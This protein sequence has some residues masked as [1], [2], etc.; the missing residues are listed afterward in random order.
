MTRTFH[1]PER[2][3]SS[4]CRHD[5]H[6]WGGLFSARECCSYPIWDDEDEHHDVAEDVLMTAQAIMKAAPHVW[7]AADNPWLVLRFS[8]HVERAR[9]IY[10]NW[11]GPPDYRLWALRTV[12]SAGAVTLSDVLSHPDG[13][14]RMI[15]LRF[16][17]H[18]AESE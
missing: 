7:C 15:G 10:D 9:Q 6:A 12:L 5:D 8:E 17:G 14:I 1:H 13:P 11:P 18:I 4:D 2:P 3:L 16:A